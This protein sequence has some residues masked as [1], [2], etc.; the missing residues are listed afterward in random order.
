MSSELNQFTTERARSQKIT[1]EE[2]IGKKFADRGIL[3]K[4]TDAVFYSAD[5]T[6][7]LAFTGLLYYAPICAHLLNDERVEAWLTKNTDNK[8]LSLSEGKVKC[9]T[10]KG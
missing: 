7:A 3:S 2:F 10:E 9:F 5:R 1:A 6:S 4:R 8:V